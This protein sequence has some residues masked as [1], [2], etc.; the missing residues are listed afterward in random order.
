MAWQPTRPAVRIVTM[1]EDGSVAST[2]GLSLEE[3]GQRMKSEETIFPRMI[4]SKE[5]DR[6]VRFFN[7][8]RPASQDI[9]N[10]GQIALGWHWGVDNWA[11]GA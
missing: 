8:G 3:A 10:C 11:G 9:P 2:S 6:L 1:R 7:C 4:L 5:A